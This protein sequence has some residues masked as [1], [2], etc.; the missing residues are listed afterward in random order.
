MTGAVYTN[1]ET[2]TT[3]DGQQ[4]N[5]LIY[6]APIYNEKNE[7]D[8]VMELSTN[9]TALKVLEGELMK[10]EEA[11]RLS[12]TTTPARFLWCSAPISISWTPTPGPWTYMVSIKSDLTRKTFFDLAPEDYR[13]ELRSFFRGQRTFWGNSNRQTRTE[14]FFT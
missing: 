5:V 11:Y 3:T 1:E 14:V 4:A 9:I 2:V 13:E 6:T 7:I 8:M 12:S 10:S